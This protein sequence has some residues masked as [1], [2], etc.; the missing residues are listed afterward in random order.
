MFQ[1]GNTMLQEPRDIW[2]DALNVEGISFP[3]QVSLASTRTYSKFGLIE[4][5]YVIELK[6]SFGGHFGASREDT[7]H[8]ITEDAVDKIFKEIIDSVVQKEKLSGRDLIMVELRSEDPPY[9]WQSNIGPLSQLNIKD[10]IHQ[11]THHLRYDKEV[12]FLEGFKIIISTRKAPAGGGHS[13]QSVVLLDDLLTVKN[14]LVDVGLHVKA[15]LCLPASL[16]LLQTLEKTKIKN[17]GTFW[18]GIKQGALKLCLDAEVSPDMTCT[19]QDVVRFENFLQRRIFVYVW[20]QGF[21]IDKRYKGNQNFYN[22]NDWKKQALPLYIFHDVQAEH[23]YAISNIRALFSSSQSSFCH[24]CQ[25]PHSEG[26]SHVCNKCCQKC[27]QFK[28]NAKGKATVKITCSECSKTF[29]T[30]ECYKAHRAVEVGRKFSLCDVAKLCPECGHSLRGLRNIK[31]HECHVTKCINCKQKMATE[32]IYSHRCSIQQKQLLEP[33]TKYIFF[34]IECSQDYSKSSSVHEPNLIIAQTYDGEEPSSEAE[35]Q[36]VIF[37]LFPKK[38][39][40]EKVPQL[41]KFYTECKDSDEVV[42]AFC[43][44]L[45]KDHDGYTVL[46]HNARGY[47]LQFIYGWLL[48][49]SD[50]DI[51]KHLL[52][53]DSEEEEEDGK[54]KAPK[55]TRPP[56]SATFVGTSILFMEIKKKGTHIRFIDSY[57]FTQRKLKEFP[58]T[59]GLTEAKKGYFPHFFNKPENYAY[60]GPYPD[61]RL[62]GC[63]TMSMKDRDEFAEWYQERKVRERKDEDRE[64]ELFD[65]LP[66]LI[67]YCL[68]DV[69][70]LRRGCIMFRQSLMDLFKMDPFQYMTLAQSAFALYRSTFMPKDSMAVIEER[71]HSDNQSGQAIEWMEY[72][73]EKDPSLRIQHAWNSVSEKVIE[74]G[75]KKYKADG[76]DG[77]TNTVYEYNGCMWHGCPKCHTDKNKINPYKGKT[78]GEIYE[79]TMVREAAIRK[80]GYKMIIC[81]SHD[82]VGKWGQSGLRRD[83]LKAKDPT[84]TRVLASDVRLRGPPNIRESLHGGRTNVISHLHRFHGKKGREVGKYA[85]VNSMYPAVLYFDIFPVGH[86][87]LLRF[88]DKLMTEENILNDT[89][90]GVFRCKV[91]PPRGLT[92]A[93]LPVFMN[94]KLHYTLCRTCA[95]MNNQ[96]RCTHNKEERSLTHTW[97]TP[98]LKLALEEG[99]KIDVFYSGYQWPKERRTKT[100]FQGYISAFTKVKQE[101]SGWPKEVKTQEQKDQYIKDYYEETKVQDVDGKV[102]GILLEESKI[103]KNKGLRAIAKLYLNSLWGKISQRGEYPST[104]LL[105]NQTEFDDWVFD[106][107]Y[108]DKHIEFRNDHVIEVSYKNS[109]NRHKTNFNINPAI[110]AFTTSYARVRL[111]AALK[112]LGDQVLGYDTD[113]VFYAYDVDNPEHKDLG[114]SEALGAFKDELEGDYMVDCWIAGGPK[115]YWF[116]LNTGEEKM[117]LKGF[118]LNYRSS[119]QLNYLSMLQVIIGTRENVNVVNKGQFVKSRKKKTVS[120]VDTEKL[121]SYV[122]SK[123][124]VID[125]RKTAALFQKTEDVAFDEE[126]E[127]IPE[128]SK[129]ELELHIATKKKEELMKKEDKAA[130]DLLIKERQKKKLETSQLKDEASWGYIHDINTLPFGY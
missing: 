25:K 56:L 64:P 121:Y 33:S 36:T 55:R 78:M 92:H 24:L 62:Y 72:L 115:N 35:P 93:V 83:L 10:I 54:K 107:K 71:H 102:S 13:S 12:R 65:F 44:W 38:R 119:K 69:D 20:E 113:S 122:Y 16:V 68:S 99:Y 9:M 67:L 96:N 110:G 4:R 57:S 17:T 77:K 129:E 66:E 26:D 50:S 118:S 3:V 60:K 53:G 91:S 18:A 94:E 8:D 86:P 100:L 59:F 6:D 43:R 106:D 84:L 104:R 42:G 21:G 31:K 34:D 89:L 112:T 111:Y 58:E 52:H 23:Y 98:E 76:Y 29:A 123:A 120:S 90:F 11:I 37:G 130:Y 41:A 1:K 82:W 30:D 48:M 2:N 32:Q 45:L 117:R 15:P 124:H 27:G 73:M 105:R 14:C 46:A 47:D 114:S 7:A 63:N 80:A 128:I 103:S 70:I 79:E 127:L 116:R 108:H 19:Y 75:G 81:W 40:E 88:G 101:S 109:D 87:E 61:S 95:M 28:C 74:S 49:N 125:D 126:Q 22:R 51:S 97:E 85:D 5:G 39:V